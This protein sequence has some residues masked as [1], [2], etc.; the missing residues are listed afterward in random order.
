MD[1]LYYLGYH[2]KYAVLFGMG[3]YKEALSPLQE[4][5]SKSFSDPEIDGNYS[6]YWLV[7]T[8]ADY[9]P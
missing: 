2:A 9:I 1:R 3:H 4:M 5:L 7:G 6:S 8:A